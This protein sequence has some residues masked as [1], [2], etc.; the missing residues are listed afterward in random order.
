MSKTECEYLNRT[1][2]DN[3]IFEIMLLEE[4]RNINHV[5]ERIALSME[6]ERYNRQIKEWLRD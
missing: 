6:A 3:I 1:S 5:L 2:T 4:L